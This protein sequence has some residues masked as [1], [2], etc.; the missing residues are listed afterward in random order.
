MLI[1]MHPTKLIAGHTT[2]V[3][4]ICGEERLDGT[5]VGWLEFH[6]ADATKPAL[7]TEQET[8][9]PNRTALEYWA[10]DLEPV[11]LEGALTRATGR[12][13]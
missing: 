13:L 9:Q 2:Y 11:Y 4:R 7:L 1:R 12:L 3:V 5:W 10:D 8:S 6:S